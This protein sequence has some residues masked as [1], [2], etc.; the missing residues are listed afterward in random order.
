[1]SD[2]Y[3]EA[4]FQEWLELRLSEL[5]KK[6][7]NTD[8]SISILRNK[9]KE[10]FNQGYD[11]DKIIRAAMGHNPSGRVWQ[12]LHLPKDMKP[13]P[14]RKHLKIAQGPLFNQVQDIVKS[15]EMPKHKPTD[16]GRRAAEALRQTLAEH[17][18]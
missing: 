17:K 11:C 5:G 15:T 4:L 1:M 8:R 16:Y 14:S 18:P 9:L 6:V 10:W 12:G 7:K 3:S 2:M 13:D